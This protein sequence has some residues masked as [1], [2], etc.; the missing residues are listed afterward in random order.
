MGMTQQQAADALEITRRGFQMY[1]AGVVNNRPRIIPKPI[2]KLAKL[3]EVTSMADADESP[4]PP[5]P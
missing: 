5:P 1:E 2:I 4:S 3:I